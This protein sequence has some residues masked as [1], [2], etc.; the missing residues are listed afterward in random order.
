MGCSD[1]SLDI[2][3]LVIRTRPVV[4]LGMMVQWVIAMIL[5]IISIGFLGEF[6]VLSFS[7]RNRELIY[8]CTL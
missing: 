1:Q 2:G 4:L 5:S 7:D 6:H 3:R 8:F